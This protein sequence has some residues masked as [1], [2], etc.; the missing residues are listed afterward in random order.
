[1]KLLLDVV[2]SSQVFSGDTSVGWNILQHSQDLL[3][4]P[5]PCLWDRPTTNS[6]LRH[7]SR[8][9]L[10]SLPPLEGDCPGRTD[11]LAAYFQV[12][13]PSGSEILYKIQ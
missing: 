7:V 8:F 4:P 11:W 1:M 12:S 3:F 10:G 5:A 9:R 6:M 2:D 13:F